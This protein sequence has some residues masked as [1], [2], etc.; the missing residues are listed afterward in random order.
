MAMPNQEDDSKTLPKKKLKVKKNNRD[1][2]QPEHPKNSNQQTK[3]KSVD[4]ETSNEAKPKKTVNIDESESITKNNNKNNKKN[5]GDQKKK[6]K[7]KVKPKEKDIDNK[8]GPYREALAE[9]IAKKKQVDERL[10]GASQK[11]GEAEQ[12]TS[13]PEEIAQRDER[14]YYLTGKGKQHPVRDMQQNVRDILIHSGFN[15]LENQHFVPEKEV[16]DQY[17]LISG[18]VLEE[19]YYLGETQKN[20]FQI[21]PEQLLKFEEI[22]LH[23]NFDSSKFT[24]IV[25]EYNERSLN[26]SYFFQK[27][28]EDLEF[29]NVDIK[30]LI[31]EIPELK[32]TNPR[33]TST[34]LRSKMDSTWLSTIKAILDK[35]NLPLKV[36]STG[37]W[38]KREPKQTELVLKSHYGASCI[39]V[40]DDV[41]LDIGKIIVTEL[42]D[43]LEIEDIEF[44]DNYLVQEFNHN[45]KELE[46]YCNNIK[47]ASVG[48]FQKKLLEKFEID[49]PVL[50]INFGLEHLV[51]VREGMDDIRELMYPQFHSAWKLNDQDIAKAIEYIQKPKTEIGKEIAENLYNICLKNNSTPSP[52]EFTVWDGAIDRDL[53]GLGSE[54]DQISN[55]SP[56]EF[57]NNQE[58]HLIVKV[59]KKDKGNKLC[60]PAALNEIV[61]KNGE[62]FGVNKP[63]QNPDLAGAT[64]TEINFLGAFSNYVGREIEK[65]LEEGNLKDIAEIKAGIIRD[66]E[67]INLQLDGRAVRFISSNNKRIDVKGPMFVQVDLKFEDINSAKNNEGS[68]KKNSSSIKTPDL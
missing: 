26:I 46:V 51:M 35:D 33:L 63:E 8:K 64:K 34:T 1:K 47:I 5:N 42:L 37:V 45:D 49:I 12:I 30:Y 4:S 68:N 7:L 54:T 18:T 22:F 9:V 44:K 32:G 11:V 14:I 15:E 50:Y 40:D 20:K 53:S 28:K 27:L 55:A 31:E 23:L 56:E 57:R 59:S 48:L 52:C 21:S 10:L 39:I 38:F 25:N 58:K 3:E 16:F 60:G 41:T 66:M 65:R 24:E 29:S 36:F 2:K 6:V 13:D 19:T 17:N 62:I 61:V 43:R 67:D